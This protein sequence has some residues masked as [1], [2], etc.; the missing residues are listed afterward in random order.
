VS[1]PRHS[2]LAAVHT[3]HA[4]MQH[5]SGYW[6]KWSFRPRHCCEL[7][8]AAEA[9]LH[10]AKQQAASGIKLYYPELLASGGERLVLLNDLR[11]AIED[12]SIAVHLQPIVPLHGQGM[13]RLEALARWDHPDR[14][15]VSPEHFIALAETGGQILP[16]TWVV[17]RR[18]LEQAAPLIR[19]ERI[20]SVSIN[21]SPY[22]LLDSGFTE[23]FSTIISQHGIAPSS[24]ML[25]ITESI[26]MSERMQRYT[27]MSLREL[28]VEL[29][30]DDFG[31]GHSSLSK[32]RQLPVTELKIDR[33]FVTNMLNDEND[34]AI[35]IATIQLAHS[36]GLDIVAEGIEDAEVLQRLSELG[37]DYAQ[38]RYICDALPLAE[39]H[40]WIN[41][42][43]ISGCVA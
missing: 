8:Q 35:V 31:T 14:G 39:L 17:I 2:V 42:K 43:K 25:E 11:Q 1:H 34:E 20:E 5:F 16:L 40:D 37:C 28:G 36:L 3:V 32:L 6:A 26:A 22:C 33:S 30:I 19:D 29:S 21:L 18:A 9:A 12:E 38:G 4:A 24:V 41:N 10:A 7:V 27:V 23:K 15:M 13:M